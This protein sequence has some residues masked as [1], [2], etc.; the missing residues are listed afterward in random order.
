VGKELWGRCSRI[1]TDQLDVLDRAPDGFPSAVVRF[2]R[3]KSERRALAGVAVGSAV[4]P[5]L[6]QEESG[7]GVESGFDSWGKGA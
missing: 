3:E 4:K 6:R 7:E 2:P 1:V 5:P